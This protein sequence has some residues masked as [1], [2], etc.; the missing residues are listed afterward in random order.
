MA[1]LQ[2]ERGQ[3]TLLSLAHHSSARLAKDLVQEPAHHSE[4]LY[5]LFVITNDT[6]M[7][8]PLGTLHLRVL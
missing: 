3:V 1:Q 2:T 4:M 6:D 7:M 5:N 8:T